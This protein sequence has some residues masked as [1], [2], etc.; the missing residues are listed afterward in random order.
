MKLLL[1]NLMLIFSPFYCYNEVFTTADEEDVVPYFD[2]EEVITKIDEDEYRK[3][4]EFSKDLFLLKHN[5]DYHI[6]KTIGISDNSY[7]LIGRVDTGNHPFRTENLPEFPYLAYYENEELIWEEVLIGWGYGVIKDAL[8]DDEDIIIIGNYETI[9]QA[10]MIVIAKFNTNGVLKDKILLGGNHISEGNSIFNYQ[11]RYYFVGTTFANDGDFY[12]HHV[13]NQNVVVGFVNKKNFQVHEVSLLGNDGNNQ[14]YGAQMNNDKLYIYM[15]FAGSGY[16]TNA[17]ED[18]E[19]RAIVSYD[20]RL[21]YQNHVSL[22]NQY[23][24]KKSE[25]VITKD[26]LA[27]ISHDYWDNGL[28]FSYYDWELNMLNETKLKLSYDE[29][30]FY[31][32]AITI[33]DYITICCN[34]KKGNSYAY[35]FMIFSSDWQM[36]HQTERPS[37]N[38]DI[39]VSVYLINNIIYCSSLT[40]WNGYQQPYLESHLHIKINDA[41]VSFNGLY[42]SSRALTNNQNGSIFGKTTNLYEYSLGEYTFVL[43]SVIEVPV[44][45]NIVNKETY[46]CGLIL[47]FNGIGY[48]NGEKIDAGYVCWQEGSYLLELQGVDKTLYYTFTVKKKS[49][50]M[51][52]ISIM[53]HIDFKQQYQV[54]SPPETDKI[55][56]RYQEQKQSSSSYYIYILLTIAI[57]GVAI[58]LVIPQRRKKND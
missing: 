3:G 32:Y 34:M 36:I 52:D 19:F 9:T 31:D 26:K 43:P 39:P 27:I 16:F 29:G 33:G 51:T 30:R 24:F 57:I 50:G 25:L 2:D 28:M 5:Y 1:L 56:I 20:Y 11:D 44:R 12:S 35:K 40:K 17:N 42:L 46:D 53:E 22:D 37:T 4:I 15:Q 13:N 48:L 55:T 6:T 21:E 7:Y 54:E 23:R 10:N 47:D 41:S 8:I 58:G 38:N 49:L 14:L 45:I 18:G